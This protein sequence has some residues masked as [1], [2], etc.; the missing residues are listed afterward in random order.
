MGVESNNVTLFI[1]KYLTSTEV[2]ALFRRNYYHKTPTASFKPS[3]FQ[4]LLS[5][6][7]FGGIGCICG[8]GS[9]RGFVR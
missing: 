5:R 3:G 4:Y 6:F 8:V 7:C 2:G 1:Y 9:I